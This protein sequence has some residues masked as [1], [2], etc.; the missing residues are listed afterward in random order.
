MSEELKTRHGCLTAYLII[1]MVMNSAMSLA[2]LAAG[3]FFLEFMPGAPGWSMPVLAVMGGINLACAIALWSWKKWGFYGFCGSAAIT[4]VINLSIGID[5]GQSIA[6][7]AGVIVLYFVLQ[8]GEPKAWT[9]L[10]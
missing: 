8:T 2:Y 10:E 3:D 9:L 7:L 4:L 5:P 6:G 1:M